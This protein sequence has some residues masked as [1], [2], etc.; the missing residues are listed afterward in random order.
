M[1]PAT[2]SASG[3]R[4]LPKRLISVL[5]SASAPPDSS[6][7]RPIIAP[8]AMMIA[9]WPRVLPMPPSMVAT[10]S[11]G[12]TPATSATMMLTSINATNG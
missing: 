3:V 11:A 5:A 8:R 9:M 6:M 12:L 1:K 7:M 2:V 10:R 4:L